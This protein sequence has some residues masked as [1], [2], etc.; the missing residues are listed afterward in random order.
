MN[1]FAFEEEEMPSERLLNAA[2][3]GRV[4][5]VL[6]AIRA[7]G[8]VDYVRLDICPTLIACMRQYDECLQVLMEHGAHGDIGN[9]IGW[10]ALHEA[11]QKEDPTC[12]KI[13]LQYPEQTQFTKQDKHGRTALVAAITSNR[14]DNAELLVKACPDLLLLKDNEG[15]NLALWAVQEKKED[16]LLWLLKKGVSPSET[17]EKGL[18]ATSEV[19]DWEEGKRLIE[20]YGF[21]ATERQ[22]LANI[23]PTAEVEAV[24]EP[25]PVSNPFGLGGVSKKKN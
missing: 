2:S 23:N 13:L 11:S 6:E 14:T 10:T 8:D 20:E 16:W 22:K 18:S 5:Q 4:D 25:E 21:Q 9:R 17:N 3:F 19:G 15:S 12:L 7:E 24:S 1:I